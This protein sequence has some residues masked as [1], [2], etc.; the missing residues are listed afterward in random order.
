METS[1]YFTLSEQLQIAIKTLQKGNIEKYSDVALHLCKKLC[2]LYINELKDLM[3]HSSYNL[4]YSDQKL[5]HDLHSI[6]DSSEYIATLEIFAEF[7]NELEKIDENSISENNQ[8]LEKY[9]TEWLKKSI[10][11]MSLISDY[12]ETLRKKA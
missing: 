8:I 1:S 2:R 7:A 12:I 3:G 4:D 9:G 11:D 5:F 6:D 10:D